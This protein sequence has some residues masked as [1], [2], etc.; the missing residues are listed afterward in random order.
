M[1]SRETPEAPAGGRAKPQPFV[2]PAMPSSESA[3]PAERKPVGAATGASPARTLWADLQSQA[4]SGSAGIY[5]EEDVQSR[6]SAL[7]AKSRESEEKLRNEYE[8][9]LVRERATVAEALRQFDR[10]RKSYFERVE[11]EVVQ[12][13]L[14][15]ARKILHREA[16]TDP[17]VLTG[18]IRVALEKVAA[19]SRVKLI[20][21]EHEVFKWRQVIGA[22]KNVQPHAEVVGDPALAPGCCVLE[23]E[24]G[25]SQISL[26]HQ[27]REIE[28]GLLDLLAVRAAS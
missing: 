10:Q 15:I 20:V 6:L 7:E 14:A 21:P 1:F 4:K 24:V 25:S 16:Q 18:T 5:S 26:D 13:A 17:L 12:L 22:L 2:Y 28:R 11:A 8:A 23:T 19:G 3:R 27:F 9:A